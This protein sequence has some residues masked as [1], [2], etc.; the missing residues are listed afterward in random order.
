MQILVF[1][2]LQEMAGP[3]GM[4][5]GPGHTLG[6]K[7]HFRPAGVSHSSARNSCS[8]KEVLSRYKPEIS[9]ATEDRVGKWEAE[10]STHS[11]T[12]FL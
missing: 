12:T 8:G 5:P 1:M 4:G 2:L 3:R 7:G 6:L 10:G 9:I 11:R